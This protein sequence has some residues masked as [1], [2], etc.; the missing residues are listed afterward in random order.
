MRPRSPGSTI[1][2]AVR[3]LALIAPLLMSTPFLGGVAALLAIGSASAASS[4]MGARTPVP[5]SVS[6]APVQNGFSRTGTTVPSYAPDRILVQ[7]TSGAYAGSNLA[8]AGDRGVPMPGA[9][10]GIA[11]ID[12]LSRRS[13]VLGLSRALIKP[14]N[15]RL[16]APL[17]LERWFI[18]EL[19]PGTDIP[20]AVDEY[21]SDP[22]VE[23]ASPDWTLFPAFVPSDPNYPQNWGDNNTG[24]LPSAQ[25][26]AGKHTGPLVGT[27]GWDSGAQKA[28][29]C[30]PF[31]PTSNVIIAILD[32]GVDSSH[33]D[34][35]GQ[36]VAGYN[37]FSF[38]TNTT[39]VIGHGTCCAG[40]AVE[41]LNSIGSCGIAPWC[42]V[43]P[44]KVDD[45]KTELVSLVAATNA[46]IYAAD[47]SANIISMS[48]GAFLSSSWAMDAAIDYAYNAGVTLLA[49]TGNW[50]MPIISYPASNA[51]VIAVG[52]AAPCSGDPS[53]PLGGQG[54]RKRSS[55]NPNLCNPGV[56]PD[57]YGC[58]CD[59]EYWWGSDYGAS[60]TIN[61]PDAVD[62]LGPTILPTTDIVGAGGYD[63]GD[64]YR[65]MNG[66]SCATPYVAGV[67]GLIKLEHP[68]WTPAQVRAQLVNTATAVHNVE[69]KGT[70]PKWDPHSGYG[71][72]NAQGAATC[73]P[74]T[75]P[76]PPTAAFAGNPTTGCAPLTVTF[77]DQS[78]GSPT[79]WSW[80]FGDGSV[81]ALQNPVH[82]YT[83]PGSYTVAETVQNA[84]GA[85]TLT[86]TNYISIPCP[87]PSSTANLF[88]LVDD[89]ISMRLLL[90]NK[91]TAQTSVYQTYPSD[92]L[93]SG[94]IMALTYDPDAGLF[95][96]SRQAA[97]GSS[98]LI[99]L[100]P[101]VSGPLG[102]NE[103]P[104]A[105]SVERV[106]GIE[107]VNKKILVM[108]GLGLTETMG[109]I[110][111]LGNLLASSNPDAKKDS[112][113]VLNGPP[114]APGALN[115]DPNSYMPIFQTVTG[116]PVTNIPPT[117]WKPLPWNPPND[118]NNTM[119]DAAVDPDLPN[120]IYVTQGYK[121]PYGLVD[122]QAPNYNA[123]NIVGPYAPQD[124]IP[125]IAFAALGPPACPVEG[126]VF[127]DQNGDGKQDNGEPGTSGWTVT[128][129]G[130]GNSSYSATTNAYGFY[131]IAVPGPGTYTL[132]EVNQPGT[133]ET[134]PGTGSYSIT[135]PPCPTDE[136]D[137][138][139]YYCGDP[140]CAP[141]PACLS[142]WYSFQECNGTVAHDVARGADGTLEGIGNALPQWVPGSLPQACALN[143]PATPVTWVAV[144][145]KPGNRFGSGS[146]AIVAY[147][148]TSYAGPAPCTIVDKST[149]S[150]LGIAGISGYRLFISGG[151]VHLQ[152]GT[153][154]PNWSDHDSNA[155]VNDGKWH[156]IVAR[157]CRDPGNL[158]AAI[159]IDG[160][161]QA[162]PPNTVSIGNI[163]VNKELTVGAN[164]PNT[165]GIRSAPFQGDL[166]PI[167]LYPC[168][169][170]DED[171]SYDFADAFRGSCHDRCQVDAVTQACPP[172][173]VVTLTVFTTNP[174]PQS[175]QYTISG[176]PGS[177]NSAPPTQF[178]PATG[179]VNISGTTVPQMG[180]AQITVTIPP[181]MISN[182]WCCYTVTVRNM[183]TGECCQCSG[184][185]YKECDV[186]VHPGGG[187]SP[188][189][190][191]PVSPGDPTPLQFLVKNQGGNWYRSNYV[192]YAQSADGDSSN[193]NVR[194]NDLAPGLPVRGNLSL[195]P[196]QQQAIS[197][198]VDLMEFQPLAIQDVVL[199][200]SPESIPRL[201]DVASSSFLTVA[202]PGSHGEQLGPAAVPGATM[203]RDLRIG[204]NPFHDRTSISFGLATPASNVEAEVIDVNGRMV[205][206]LYS[207]TLSA[208]AQHLTWDGMD[209][210]GQP[211][212]GGI[213]FARVRI[214]PELRSTILV[215]VR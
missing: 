155:S 191:Q 67:C 209:E 215:L 130:L 55:N 151:K 157:V 102:K 206:R 85:N 24:Q 101:K 188:P 158:G 103:V 92:G 65:Y 61:A 17:G 156:V 41:A 150:P 25:L 177:C 163:D 56:W 37:F 57:P 74:W 94:N 198:S 164:G 96:A 78:T 29:D 80:D 120:A 10:T 159:F 142:A 184:K 49:A 203:S 68:A 128:L 42:Q 81:S 183:Y 172:T 89:G 33:P 39:D 72:V 98:W 5:A 112:D 141:V 79:S 211:C 38:N 8:A 196:G 192:I 109:Q 136:Y 26:P 69:T 99:K 86:Q 91:S 146:F 143:F 23:H 171:V 182:T 106:V 185:I 190:I 73:N 97:N 40:V 122:L 197:V 46:I 144:P 204:P 60:A 199:S 11:S 152:Y 181:A 160:V 95:L 18:F 207:G 178:S 121:P 111:L 87:G 93:A 59:G 137:F 140:T 162:F 205:R 19:P 58:T 44:L 189:G 22:N 53:N 173:A 6:F 108:Y 75:W 84:G 104:L 169:I 149:F 35:A 12:A 90:I 186:V 210:R 200:L 3:T 70:N 132:A 153:G 147:V 110:D 125:A 161:K 174:G 30:F 88:G 21:S 133:I 36:L 54:G 139:N 208:G 105:S 51:E 77:T 45:D 154:I 127:Y 9:V 66:T 48:F 175:F 82:T 52:A 187:G 117:T 83:S 15:R 212:P 170:S 47:H 43:M 20:A 62:I 129:T 124:A 63:P 71:L 214:G 179:I 213:Y 135:V 32:T 131:S 100:D 167:Q 1:G 27:P 16:A 34:L 31:V 13:G 14:G 50:N 193:H 168:C 123:Y 119:D 114:A 145:D 166:G 180:S 194:L 148:N 195:A 126:H 138:G 118:D 113:Y 7:F 64:Y 28:W 165:Q 134:L 4:P 2:R 107:Y 115:F 202:Q 176:V 116:P 76:P 201:D